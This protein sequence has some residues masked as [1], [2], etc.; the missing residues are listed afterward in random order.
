MEN[1]LVLFITTDKFY[2]QH[3][4]K[5]NFKIKPEQ[6]QILRFYKTRRKVV[7]HLPKTRQ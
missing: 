7:P 6:Q 3:F 1:S 4:T 2:S 5:L